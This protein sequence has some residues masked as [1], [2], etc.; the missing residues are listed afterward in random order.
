MIQ[1][2]YFFLNGDVLV[3]TQEEVAAIVEMN[4]RWTF[5]TPTR[6]G[7]LII[8]NITHMLSENIEGESGVVKPVTPAQLRQ[9]SQQEDQRKD[10][11]LDGQL[12]NPEVAK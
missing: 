5:K 1:Y 6:Y 2:K 10:V 3:L 7:S 11:T 9:Q 4:G 12:A 8:S